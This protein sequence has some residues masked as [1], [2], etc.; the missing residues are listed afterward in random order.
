MGAWAMILDIVIH[1]DAV[2]RRSWSGGADDRPLTQLGERQALYLA[3]LLAS[4]GVRGLFTSRASRCR[5]SLEPLSRLTG[6][7]LTVVEEFV[8]TGGYRPPA[9]WESP[10]RGGHPLGGALAAGSAVRGLRRIAEFI[11]DGRGVLCSYGD[12]I[13]ALFAF[14]CGAHDLTMPE[15][16]LF[17]EKG[18]IFTLRMEGDR[19]QLTGEGP[20]EGF[21]Q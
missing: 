19:V 6:L 18:V 15:R 10:D 16:R 20:P 1:M 9:G 17:N 13:P 8:D 12:V 21:P 14:L 2:D 5:T 11:A 7:P 4:N 3:E